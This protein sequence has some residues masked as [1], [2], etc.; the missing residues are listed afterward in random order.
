MYT[1]TE[2]L[3]QTSSLSSPD[4]EEIFLPR[5]ANSWHIIIII[6]IILFW[7]YCRHFFLLSTAE[8]LNDVHATADRC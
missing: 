1:S 2:T 3:E 5:F 4:A 6:I 8:L 7:R